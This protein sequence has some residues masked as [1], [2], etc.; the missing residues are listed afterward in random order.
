M[1]SLPHPRRGTR[2]RMLIAQSSKR[3]Y[4]QLARNYHPDLHPQATEDERRAS[5][6]RFAL[7]VTAA[8]QTLVA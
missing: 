1:V 7:E 8:Y 5:T 4:R 3:A 2:G 6:E